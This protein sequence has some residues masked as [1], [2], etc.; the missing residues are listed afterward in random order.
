MSFVRHCG[1]HNDEYGMVPTFR[2]HTIT[3][4]LSV[5]RHKDSRYTNNKVLQ[6]LG[7]V[8]RVPEKGEIIYICRKQEIIPTSTGD[9]ILCGEHSTSKGLRY[10]HKGPVESIGGSISLVYQ[11]ERMEEVGETSD[12]IGP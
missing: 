6:Q 5:Y 8:G 1:S 9:S 12:Y 7:D 2:E 11:Q 3:I 4:R 10:T